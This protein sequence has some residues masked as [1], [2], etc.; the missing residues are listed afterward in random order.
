[1]SLFDPARPPPR[2]PWRL[3]PL[4]AL[5]LALQPLSGAVVQGSD[6]VDAPVTAGDT[7]ADLGDLYAWHDGA[8]IVV[9]LTYSPLLAPLDASVYDDEVLYT[10]CIDNTGTA[11]E[12]LDYLD[13]DA[14]NACDIPIYVRM[15]QDMAGDWGVEVQDLPGATGTFSGPVEQILD[16]GGGTRAMV[17]QFDDPFFFDLEGYIATVQ[18]MLDD[19]D[20]FDLAF[21]TLVSGATS[22]T[23]AGT[24]TMAIVLELDQTAAAAGNDFVQIWATTGRL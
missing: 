20:P 24:N 15:G 18:N 12:A 9:V 23:L 14:D 4:V 11:A 8:T 2:R 16:G 10:I 3:A 13:N 7:A 1:M 17:G 21:S 6:H 19:S 22:D 5:A